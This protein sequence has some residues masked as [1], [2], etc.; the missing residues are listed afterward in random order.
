MAG[1]EPH[2]TS[3]LLFSRNGLTR[4]EFLR[5]S[6]HSLGQAVRYWGAV[7][8]EWAHPVRSFFFFVP[9]LAAMTLVLGR[10]FGMTAGKRH[11][12]SVAVHCHVFDI[13]ISCL[14]FCFRCAI[15]LIFSSEAAIR[16]LL[17]VPSSF[18]LC[19][20]RYFYC[21]SPGL[22]PFLL[23]IIQCSYQTV[24]SPRG[25]RFFK[26]C[27]STGALRTEASRILVSTSKLEYFP[28]EL[29]GTD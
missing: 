8:R 18:L 10:P 16:L 11:C 21:C 27:T 5:R 4:R 23:G 24:A 2:E 29:V 22:T 17:L 25:K 7:Q 9:V 15:V 13:H 19:R 14:L 20:C 26:H 6:F 3:R 28:P 12:K 1:I